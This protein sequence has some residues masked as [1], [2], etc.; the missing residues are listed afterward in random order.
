MAYFLEV[1]FSDGRWQQNPT[2]FPTWEEAA[3]EGERLKEQFGPSPGFERD[4]PPVLRGK[5]PGLPENYRGPK[6]RV[7]PG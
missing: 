4:V 5:L 1:Q 2:P 3:E 6:Y 7:I